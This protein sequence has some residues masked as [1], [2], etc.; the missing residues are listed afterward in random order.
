M[1]FGEQQWNNLLPSY[2]TNEA[3]GRLQEALEQFYP[4]NRTEI[5]YDDFYKDYGYEYFMQGDILKEIRSAHWDKDNASY[6]KSYPDALVLTNTCDISFE[7]NR[8]I[9]PKQCLF[10]PLLKLDD[11]LE[12]LKNA[13]YTDQKINNF[14][15]NLIAQTY[16]N[17]FYLPKTGVGTAE[18]I[19]LFDRIFW[20]P[21]EELKPL[22][23]T[24]NEEREISLTQYGFYL[25]VLKLSYHFCRLPEQCDRE[26]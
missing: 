17:L 14:K 23:P 11:Y 15:K 21:I 13:G 8:N 19:V 9:N 20:Y 6:Q 12:D 25:L 16:S 3:K 1:A 4:A 22:L 18:R 26:A 10:A 7:N 5:S 24:I 2:L